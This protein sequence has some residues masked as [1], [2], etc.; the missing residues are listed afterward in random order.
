ME[1]GEDF[2]QY[3]FPNGFRLAW[4]RTPTSTIFGNLRI[5]HGALHEKEGEEGMAH[6]LE[7]MLIE[8]GTEKYTPEEQAIIKGDF[9]YANAF[10]SRDRT[11]IPWGMIPSGL[12]SYLDMA[13][14]MVF[15]PRLDSKTLEQQRRVVL[16]EIARSRGAPDFKDV[17]KFYWPALARDRDHTYFVLGNEKVIEAAD[18]QKLRYFHK[19]GYSPNNMILMLAGD[20]P[21]DIID[22]V[23][24]YFGDEQKGEGRPFE[25]S[26]VSPLNEKAVRYFKAEDLLDKDNPQESN[27][28]LMLGIVVPDEFHP[29][30]SNL[31]VASEILGKSWT[32]GLKRRIRS[33]EGMSYDI[34][35]SYKGD[36]RFGYFEINGKIHAKRQERAID[37][38]FEEMGK[39]KLTQDDDE[40]LRAKKRA[41]YRAAIGLRNTFRRL[42]NI[43]D[44]VNVG[45]IA[46]MDYVFEGRIPIVEQ[47]SK[48]GHVNPF[49]LQT[50]AEKY[51]PSDREKDNYVLLVRDPFGT[52][53]H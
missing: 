13:A 38:I 1:K 15:H 36:K 31:A 6:F 33:E 9:G 39:L 10:T 48:I 8:G 27:S 2:E 46:S 49:T 42:V 34:G 12:E 22:R 30:S 11:M 28:E 18:E 24:K 51:L 4:Q 45:A 5:N 37:I 3:V 32:S 25:F 16:R 43:D 23:G 53:V 29:D 50:A 52:L 14:Q 41:S 7:H 19:M 20:L 47:L 17:I 26:Q 44:P 40:V 21:A 35:S